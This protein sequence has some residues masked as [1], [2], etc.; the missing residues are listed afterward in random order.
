MRRLAEAE[1][2]L[3][4]MRVAQ[5]IDAGQRAEHPPVVDD[6]AD[7]DAA[8]ADPVI[9]A[10]AADQPGPRPLPDRALVGEG[11]LER[12]IDRLR[13]R[14]AEEDVVEPGGEHQRELR[15][16]GKGERVAE[17]EDRGEIHRR[18]LAL[19]RRGDLG[20]A[21]PGVDAPQPGGAVED[22]LPF[23][24]PV[25]HALGAGEQAR[26]RLERLVRGER[27]PEGVERIRGDGRG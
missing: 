11:D 4:Q 16:R 9:A 13:P 3:G 20:A 22:A 24:R 1:G 25:I 7:R 19:D 14:I 12:G 6:A 10:L 23:R 27:H 21:V 15:R 8:E 5:V 26:V 2:V 18:R 17:V